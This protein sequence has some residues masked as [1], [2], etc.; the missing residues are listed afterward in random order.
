MTTINAPATESPAA[1]ATRLMLAA[2]CPGGS[3]DGAQVPAGLG[4]YEPDQHAQV[5]SVAGF[6]ALVVAVPHGYIEGDAGEER[7]RDVAWLGPRARRHDE[8][9]RLAMRAGPTLPVGFAS[10]FSGD[11]AIERTLTIHAAEIR[12]HFEHTSGCEEWS[13]RLM[14]DRAAI[15]ERELDTL[16]GDAGT[17]AGYLARRRLHPR[18]QGRADAW[19]LERADRLLE[20]LADVVVEASERPVVS[21]RRDDG[22][23]ALTHDAL[24][25]PAREQ[26]AF[27]ARLEAIAPELEADGLD[28]ELSGPWPVFSF[29]PALTGMSSETSGDRGDRAPEGT[30]T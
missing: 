1:H 23:D 15:V 29:C 9:V 22:T 25:V 14:G 11:A 16:V 28:I 27:E 3:L 7:L 12:R 30:R 26:G 13:V 4:G 21:A 8:L 17:G 18:A 19:C 5:L 6:D 10:L 24:L 2:V 20:A